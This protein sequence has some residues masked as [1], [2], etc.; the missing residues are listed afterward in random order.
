MSRRS[1]NKYQRRNNN[2]DDYWDENEFGYGRHLKRILIRL[3]LSE[4]TADLVSISVIMLLI[5]GCLF[6][7]IGYLS[8]ISSN[9]VI[10][11]EKRTSQELYSP[12]TEIQE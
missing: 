4:G 1:P 7:L 9:P 11:N 2:Y 8:T 12:R 6:C 3:G 5:V 10:Y